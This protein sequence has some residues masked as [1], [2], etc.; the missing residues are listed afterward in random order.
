[1]SDFNFLPKMNKNKGRLLTFS[2][3]NVNF[4]LLEVKRPILPLNFNQE[5]DKVAFLKLANV[6][7]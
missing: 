3:L 1:M 2:V 5:K 6:S 7:S 4:K